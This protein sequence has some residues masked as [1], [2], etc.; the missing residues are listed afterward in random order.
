MVPIHITE[1][2]GKQNMSDMLVK[3]YNLRDYPDGE[4]ILRREGIEIKSV[5]APNLTP[6][7]E[8]ITHHFSLS[9]ADEA[10]NAILTIPSKCFIAVRGS[11][12][13]GFAC[14]DATARGYFGPTGVDA[15]ERGKGIGKALLMHTL[16]AMY[17]DG[18]VY[19]VIGGA[20]PTDFY[21]SCCGATVIPD[22]DPGFYRNMLD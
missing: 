7:R 18:Y 14:Y 1:K 8:W 21:A 15:D 12:I 17:G 4:E 13:L 9:W 2:E 5:M 3:L 16:N 22:S 20:G 6:V 11:Q 19:G 10:T